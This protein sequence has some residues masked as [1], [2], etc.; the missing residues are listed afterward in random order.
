M[1]VKI[2]QSCLTL[3]PTSQVLHYSCIYPIKANQDYFLEYAMIKVQH[4]SSTADQVRKKWALHCVLRCV[5]THEPTV[6]SLVYTEHGTTGQC[7][8]L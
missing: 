6:V 4:A 1:R 7:D 5:C 3:M 2:S 8:I